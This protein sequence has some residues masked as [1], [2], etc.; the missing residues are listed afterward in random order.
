MG[1]NDN[2]E[3]DEGDA[4]ISIPLKSGKSFNAE[5]RRAATLKPYRQ[6]SLKLRPGKQGYAG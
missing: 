4:A 6:S 1:V 5:F 2:I 3:P